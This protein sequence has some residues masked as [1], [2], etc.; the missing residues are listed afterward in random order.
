M[1]AVGDEPSHIILRKTASDLGDRAAALL[2][3]RRLRDSQFKPGLFADPAWDILLNLLIA[4][5]RG[6]DT[7]VT[8]VCA[9]AGVPLTTALR[10]LNMMVEERLVIRKADLE[11]ARRSWVQLAPST[12]QTLRQVLSEL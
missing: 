8:G 10:Y 4:E 1:D 3:F 11:D 12:S 6:A 2:R 5:E 9:A 7:S